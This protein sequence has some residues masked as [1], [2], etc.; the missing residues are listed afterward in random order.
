MLYLVFIAVIFGLITGAIASGKGRSFVGWFVFGS[1]L[2]IIALPAVIFSSDLAEEEKQK[3]LAK[4][5]TCPH[6]AETIKK[7]ANV[8]KHCGR[9]VPE[10]TAPTDSQTTGLCPNCGKKVPENA[11]FCRHCQHHLGEPISG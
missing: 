5:R 3:E 7:E 2:F 4:T 11:T 1:L 6:C 8:C 10:Y 9:D